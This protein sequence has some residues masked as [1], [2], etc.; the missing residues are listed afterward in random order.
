MSAGSGRGGGVVFERHDANLGDSDT[1]EDVHHRNKF[2]DRKLEMW[3]HHDGCVWFIG[4]KRGKASF[5]IRCGYDIVVDFE[6]VVF[7]NRDIERLGRICR[8]GGCRAFGHDQ[9]HAVFDERRSNHKNDQQNKN[10]VEHRRN[11]ELSQAM[12]PVF[13]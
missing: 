7:V 11:V 8:A 6:N 2:L 4:L 10:Q 5:E 13:R 3:A 9:V 12:Q 1:L